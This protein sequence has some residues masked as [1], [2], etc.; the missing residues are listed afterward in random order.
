M[1]HS[2]SHAVRKDKLAILEFNGNAGLLTHGAMNPTPY[3]I[4]ERPKRADVSSFCA[5][6]FNRVLKESWNLVLKRRW[7][8]VSRAGHNQNDT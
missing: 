6:G 4:E 5:S 1:N 7:S 8:H 2:K 3:P